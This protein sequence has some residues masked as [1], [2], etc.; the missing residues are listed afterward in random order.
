MA[1]WILEL[2]NGKGIP[3]EGNYSE[4]Y[5]TTLHGCL[6][7]VAES[8]SFLCQGK[9]TLDGF[10]CPCYHI[11][12]ANHRSAL[13]GG[14]PKILQNR[15]VACNALQAAGQGEA[16]GLRVEA[17]ERAAAEHRRGAGLGQ[18]QGQG[19]A[20]EGQGAHAALRR[21]LRAGGG[22]CSASLVD[23]TTYI[24]SQP[25]DPYCIVWLAIM[26]RLARC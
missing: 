20:E 14:E 18:Q 23:A 22:S 16:G 5:I 9:N 7:A 19:A 15:A 1:G 8:K 2:S 24:V 6:A 4:W 25:K 11:L 3:F 26:H 13:A 12:S 10:A 17:A 21:A